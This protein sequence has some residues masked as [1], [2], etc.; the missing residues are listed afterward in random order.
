MSTLR[1]PSRPILPVA[2]S[3]PAPLHVANLCIR[4]LPYRY[5]GRPGKVVNLPVPGSDSYPNADS[6]VRGF[7]RRLVGE[8][9]DVGVGSTAPNAVMFSSSA[10]GWES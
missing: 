5:I 10:A 3:S 1:I 7:F 2:T 8:A 6:A 9:S 4:E